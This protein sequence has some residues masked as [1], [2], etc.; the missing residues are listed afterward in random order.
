MAETNREKHEETYQAAVA[1]LREDSPAQIAERAGGLWLPA[2]SDS[3]Q[4]RGRLEMRSLGRDLV[5]RWPDLTFESSWPFL[6]SFPWRLM[7]LHYLAEVGASEPG[8]EWIGYR[9]LPDGLF[10]ANTVTREVEQPL[11]ERYGKNTEAFMAAGEQ[12][13]GAP[14]DLADAAF[15]VHP[16]PKLPVV[17]A[18]WGEDEEFPAKA[19]VLYERTGAQNLPLQDLRIVAELMGCLLLEPETSAGG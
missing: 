19:K 8:R 13:H 17:F 3:N 10:Y 2:E 12:L 9:E 15:V 18:L 6:L 5:V 4:G 11:A 7:A 14:L 16:F 1:R